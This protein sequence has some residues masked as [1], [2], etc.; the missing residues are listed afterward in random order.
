MKNN[1]LKLNLKGIP[2]SNTQNQSNKVLHNLGSLVSI[3]K[4]K[5]RKHQFKFKI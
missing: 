3:I 2:N 5:K 1:I 4:A